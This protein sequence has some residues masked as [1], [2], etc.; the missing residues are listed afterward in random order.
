MKQYFLVGVLAGSVFTIIGGL[1][2]WGLTKPSEVP[3]QKSSLTHED[4]YKRAY[5]NAWVKGAVYQQNICLAIMNGRKFENDASKMFQL[6]YEAD[7]ANFVKTF[8]NQ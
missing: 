4:V 3:A 5:E 7:S 1:I 8:I 6:N 2:L